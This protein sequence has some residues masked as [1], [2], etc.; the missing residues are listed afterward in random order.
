M[1]DQVA[2]Y[3]DMMRTLLA[4]TLL[5]GDASAR[6]AALYSHRMLTMLGLRLSQL[7]QMQTAALREIDALLDELVAELQGL[8]G[9]MILVPQLICHVRTLPDFATAEPYLQ[10][11]VRLLAASPSSSRQRLQS[12]IAAIMMDVQESLHQAAQ[13][14]SLMPAAVET[15][16]EPLDPA[17]KIALRQYLQGKFPSETALEI[18]NVKLAVGG[19][20]KQT[21]IVDL[22]N[23][24]QLPAS[25]VLRLDSASGVVVSKV[26]DEF[27]LIKALHEAGIMVPRPLAI[28]SDKSILG[29]PFLVVSR[30]E[31]HNV[32]DWEEVTEPSREFAIDLAHTLAKLHEV[33]ADAVGGSLPGAGVATSQRILRELAA[34]E[35]SWR[36]YGEPSIA[37]EQ[38]YA[39]LKRHIDF[40][41]GQRSIIHCDVGCHNMLGHEGRLTALLDWETAV[42][43]HPAQDLAYVKHT[44][45]QMMPWDDFLAEYEKAGG[46]I[47]DQT[48][49]DFYR[50][51]RG[52]F[53]MHYEY[54]ARSFFLSGMS[55][56]LIIAYSSQHVFQY[57]NYELHKTVKLVYERYPD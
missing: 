35:E 51:W 44:V 22:S 4:T 21:L 36:T 42:V 8:D 53:T 43:G 18:G 41:D 38:A 2:P 34:F 30:V 20:S 19:G 25:V 6:K 24:N 47:P 17:K 15:P 26:V 54:M 13:E 29:A 31:G 49:L 23:T 1:A 14:R 12:R 45:E 37:M 5:P 33:S 56:S 7:P 11:A 28:E 39:W 32:G 27:S 3:L 55:Q 9:T 16:A 10:N 52:V 48:R 57:C 40:A 50:L 46:Q